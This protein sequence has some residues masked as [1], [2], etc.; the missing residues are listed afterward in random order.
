V[1]SRDLKTWTA[2]GAGLETPAGARHGTVFAVP[3]KILKGLLAGAPADAAAE[4]KDGV[5]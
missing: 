2:L 3:E 4:K 1:R 5:Q